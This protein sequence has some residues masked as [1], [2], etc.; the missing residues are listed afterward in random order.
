MEQK[1]KRTADIYHHVEIPKELSSCVEDAIKLAGKSRKKVKMLKPWM[2]IAISAAAVFVFLINAAPVFA[3]QIYDV[4]ILGD[5]ARMVTVRSYREYDETKDIEVNIPE[6]RNS[7]HYQLEKRINSEI[8]EKMQKMINDAEQEAKEYRKAFLETGGKE[9]EF[10]PV[11]LYV[12]YD[13]KSSNNKV[14]SF[15]ISKTNVMASAFTEFYYYNIDL[16]TEKELTLA[17]VLGKD[18]RNIVNRE[19]QKQIEKWNK[20]NPD[21]QYFLPE[22]GGFTGIADNQAFYI[23]ENGNAVVVFEKYAI[24]MGAMGKREF[25]IKN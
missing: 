14:L 3:I 2:K 17:D 20:A 21:S 12:D 7:G 9:W 6:I 22:E 5:F 15:E 11:N 25:E 8:E 1:L 18:Y 4:P 23:N 16:K 13:V 10:I 24:A 19:I